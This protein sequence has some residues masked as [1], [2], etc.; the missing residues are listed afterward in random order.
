MHLIVLCT[1]GSGHRPALKV[2]PNTDSQPHRH[3]RSLRVNYRYS[4][5]VYS[6]IE[7]IF[8]WIKPIKQCIGNIK[9][10]FG[11]SSSGVGVGYATLRGACLGLGPTQ[12]THE[13]VVEADGV[14]IDGLRG[15]RDPTWAGALGG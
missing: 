11:I 3:I 5:V 4:R 2:R 9:G 10:L 1:L 8:L 7:L 6:P 15:G 12:R 14:G 13:L